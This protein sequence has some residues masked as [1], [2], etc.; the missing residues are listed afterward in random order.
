MSLG[1]HTLRFPLPPGEVPA[2][3]SRQ[4]SSCQIRAMCLQGARGKMTLAENAKHTFR[5]AE[6]RKIMKSHQRTLAQKLPN[7]QTIIATTINLEGTKI[8]LG[9]TTSFLD[10]TILQFPSIFTFLC[11]FC[12]MF[13]PQYRFIVT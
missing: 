6:Y 10:G 9:G 3:T 5:M 4:N 12:F 1:Q 11:H 8:I 2:V 13:V 7:T